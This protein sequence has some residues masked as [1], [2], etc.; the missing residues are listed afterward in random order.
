MRWWRSNWARVGPGSAADRRPQAF[1]GRSGGSSRP[2]A[3]RAT[4]S[5]RRRPSSRAVPPPCP[6]PRAQ[7]AGRFCRWRREPACG[8]EFA[9]RRHTEACWRAWGRGAARP[10][11]T[12]MRGGARARKRI[13]AR[14]RWF[15]AG[16]GPGSGGVRVGGAD[17]VGTRGLGGGGGAGSSAE[18]GRRWAPGGAGWSGDVRAWVAGRGARARGGDG[19]GWSWWRGRDDAGD[20]DRLGWG[21]VGWGEVG[22][23]GGGLAGWWWGVG[24]GEERDL[25]GAR[26]R[27]GDASRDAERGRG[28]GRWRSQVARRSVGRVA[29]GGVGDPD[30]QRGKVRLRARG[31]AIE[32]T[33]TSRASRSRRRDG[34]ISMRPR[35]AR[36]RTRWAASPPPKATA[37]ARWS[38][39]SV[40]ATSVGMREC[41]YPPR[42][43]VCVGRGWSGAR[44]RVRNWGRIR[45]RDNRTSVRSRADAYLARG[46]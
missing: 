1:E 7:R 46:K 45:E 37:H 12:R 22:W 34:F 25:D 5:A 17:R 28:R 41:D 15:V 30:P 26:A 11:A 6:R 8:W 31:D 29:G 38:V 27:S 21:V 9:R 36:G 10:I 18:L 44:P 24:G 35:R 16:V 4:G 13:A 33:A 23:V 2:A 14:W 32:A 19:C 20:R 40:P 42:G 39:T 3:G 43:E